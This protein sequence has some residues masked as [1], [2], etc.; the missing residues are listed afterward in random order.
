MRDVG[1]LKTLLA[2]GLARGRNDIPLNAGALNANT[3]M[4]EEKPPPGKGRGARPTAWQVAKPAGPDSCKPPWGQ[5]E[6]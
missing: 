3:G 1:D 5:N 2:R 4:L 6:P